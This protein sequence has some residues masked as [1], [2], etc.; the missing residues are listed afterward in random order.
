MPTH[1][2]FKVGG[3]L[4]NSSKALRKTASPWPE[5]QASKASQI[6]APRGRAKAASEQA[7]AVVADVLPT[8]G[9]SAVTEGR[10]QTSQ[11]DNPSQRQ[12]YTNTLIKNV[13]ILCRYLESTCP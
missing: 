12:T 7:E 9:D 3:S 5:K 8:H 6:T 10:L 4:D 11:R 13:Q 1:Y 2:G